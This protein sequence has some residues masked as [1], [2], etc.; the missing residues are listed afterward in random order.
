MKALSLSLFAVATVMTPAWASDAYVVRFSAH[1]MTA[2][3]H[4]AQWSDDILLYNQNDQPATIRL[5]DISN[6]TLP[7][8]WPTTITVPPRQATSLTRETR[9]H[10]W[11]PTLFSDQYT[12]W[13]VHLDVPAGITVES[14][15]EVADID[16]C[17]PEHIFNGA[18]T[19]VSMPVFHALVPPN[20]TQAKLGTDVGSTSARQNV[21][22]YNGGM[23]VAT[24]TI[25][26]RSACNNQLIESRVV[27]VPPNSIIQFE[28][29]ATGPSECIGNVLVPAWSRYILVT[30]N[31]PSFSVVSTV[32]E[33]Q[34]QAPG[35]IL[36][37]VELASSISSTF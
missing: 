3:C 31:Q 36:P 24:A 13:V 4:Q 14:R 34:A 12:I 37:L 18:I 10:P 15:D 1:G 33:A 5:L 27:S 22:I 7:A 6:G 26:V 23:D 32:T 35:N 11:G 16:I 28:G 9:D 2:G 21:A 25:D 8:G 30:V 19:K 20:I 29:F 17:T